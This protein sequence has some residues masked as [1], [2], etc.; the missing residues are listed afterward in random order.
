MKEMPELQRSFNFIHTT[1]I[2]TKKTHKKNTQKNTQKKLI[3]WS[4]VFF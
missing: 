1:K 4:M 2:N 3:F